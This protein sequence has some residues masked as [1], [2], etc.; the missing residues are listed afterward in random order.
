M[1]ISIAQFLE[2]AVV[3]NPVKFRKLI[4]ISYLNHHRYIL[5][6]REDSHLE[7]QRKRWS[8]LLL[9]LLGSQIQIQ[10]IYDKTRDRNSK[11]NKTQQE[12]NCS[13]NLKS[14]WLNMKAQ[15]KSKMCKTL[16]FYVEISETAE[17]KDDEHVVIN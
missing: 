2:V 7:R 17:C 16:K 10:E 4:G 6:I 12:T 3:F 14:C 13:L 1:L 15:L 11:I 5:E 8:S 9:L